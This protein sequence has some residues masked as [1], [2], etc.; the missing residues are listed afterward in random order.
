[1]KSI[2]G[3]R[4]GL[5]LGAL[6]LFT[7]VLYRETV[8]AIWDLWTAD[9]NPTYSHGP[10]LLLVSLYI[11]YREWESRKEELK[12]KISYLGLIGAAASGL[13]W[14]VA[15]LGSVQVI[16]MLALVAAFCSIFLSLLGFRQAKPYLFPILLLIGALPVWGWLVKYLQTISAVS[17]GWITTITIRPSIRE[18]MFIHIPAGTFEVAEGCSGIAYFIVSI[19]LALLFVYMNRIP[20]R[21]AIFFVI[22]AMGIAI[23]ANIIR[24]YVIVLSGQLTDMQSYFVKKEHFSLGW[25]I[26]AIGIS[27]ALWQAGR[28]L[29]ALQEKVAQAIDSDS[30]MQSPVYARHSTQW[31][32]IA[33]LVM[34]MLLGPMVSAAYQ[35]DVAQKYAYTIVF[36]GAVGNRS[37]STHSDSYRPIIQAG[38][39]NQEAS[40]VDVADSP[41]IYF[42]MNY[43][44]AQQQGSEAV[45]DNNRL[46]DGHRWR[47][48]SSKIINPEIAGYSDVRETLLQARNGSERV[49]WDWYETNHARTSR[50]WLAKLQNIVGIIVG[51]PSIS[52]MVLAVEPK[53][54]LASARSQLR[55][56]IR[57][58]EGKIQVVHQLN[59]DQRE[60]N[61]AE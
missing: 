20:V 39:A 29:P 54:G 12:L 35:G 50:A 26:F 61:Y 53:A 45:S 17:A 31:L 51:N 11:L 7:L 21:K 5:L 15:E 30:S 41:N 19:I 47:P 43:F 27:I 16:Q 13:L 1:M 10:L 59:K 24:V 14:F 8:L 38:D 3:N 18:G 55:A 9:N 56:F 48:L 60:N 57:E 58:S 23:V 28:F 32:G 37:K 2:T 49:V 44:Y 46:A 40:Y 4:L 42:Y 36:P 33:L 34:A 6:M 22:A 25:V 52:M